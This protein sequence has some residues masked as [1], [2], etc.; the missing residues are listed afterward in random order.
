MKRV[1][2]GHL[3][4]SLRAEATIFSVAAQLHT[5][6]VTPRAVEHVRKR[7]LGRLRAD[8][9]ILIT[10]AQHHKADVAKARHHVQ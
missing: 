7:A 10:E 4:G 5:A 8:A 1:Q 2:I 6:D 9:T 3:V